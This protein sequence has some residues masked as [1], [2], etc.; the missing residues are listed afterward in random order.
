MILVHVLA[1]TGS[2]VWAQAGI[3]F[4]DGLSSNAPQVSLMITPGN[5][6]SFR[7]R[8]TAG[9]VTYQVN[10]T[11]ITAPA[12]IRLSRSTNTFTASYS[13]GGTSWTQLGT[14]QTVSM[15]SSVLAGLAVTAHNNSLTNVATFNSVLMEAGPQVTPPSDLANEMTWQTTWPLPQLNIASNL[16]KPAMGWNAWFVVAGLGASESLV[17][18]TADAMATNG[19]GAAGYK[20][21]NID[22]TWIATP[23]RGSRDA[24]GHLL[25]E[26]N[27]YWPHGMK[28]VSDYV[29][30]KGLLM[31][32]YSDIGAIGYPVQRQPCA[33]SGHTPIW[34]P[35]PAVTRR[36]TFPGHGSVLLKVAGT[37]NWNRPRIYEAEWAY[38]S[39]SGNAY[40]VPNTST[41]RPARMSPAS[42]MARRTRFSSTLSPRRRTDFIR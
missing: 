9:D 18:S 16:L 32:G 25:P 19:L 3:M 28:Y 30:A 26:T 29:H 24:S 6:V 34:E 13:T 31:G 15:N 35:S 22:G 42:A 2:E 8:Y 4:R 10:Q 20:Y 41:F 36:R 7:Y 17:F 11:G 40:Y 5:G 14:P 39:F 21:V 38:N 1:Q 37:F 33:I 23:G 12:W 27:S